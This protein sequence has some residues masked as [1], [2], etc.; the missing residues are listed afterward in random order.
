MFFLEKR[1]FGERVTV[2]AR[3]PEG[4][5]HVGKLKLRQRLEYYGVRVGV[6][7]SA[8]ERQSTTND[9]FSRSS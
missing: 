6:F 4:L 2:R 3:L 7:L 9:F 8:P 5:R 1:T